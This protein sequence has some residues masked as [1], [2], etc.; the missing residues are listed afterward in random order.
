M[1]GARAS[2]LATTVALLAGAT[3]AGAQTVIPSAQVSV[4]GGYSTNPFLTTGDDLGV[5]SAQIGIVPQLEIID[6]TDQA[7]I[8]AFYDR[9]EYASKYDGNDGYGLNINAS[10][11]FDPRTS[12]S[13]FAS[14]S[15]SILGTANGFGTEPVIVTGT[16]TGTGSGTGTGTG[17]DTGTGTTPI[18]T[19]PIVT[20]SIIDTIGGDIGLVGFR[21]RRNALSAGLSGSY[22]P[23]EKSTWGFGANVA[24]NSYPDNGGLASSFRSYGVNTSYSRSLSERSS[25]GFQIGATLTD[26]NRLPSAKFVTPRLTYNTRLAERWTLDLAVGASFVDDGFSTG[27]AA[28]ATASLCRIAERAQFCLT[29]SRE[30]G[31]SGFGGARNQTSVTA[32][33]TYQLAE[34][35]S[36]SASGSYSQTSNGVTPLQGFQTRDQGYLSGSLTLNRRLARRLSA[37]GTLNYRDVNG[38]GV[39]IDADLG[40]RAGLSLAIGGRQ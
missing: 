20:T 12:L 19:T 30:P 10:T 28:S 23:D 7:T 16:G 1:I 40:A 33:Y 37:F 24:R 25:A 39:P 38:L 14:Y 3:G 35:T 13:F 22:R 5:A 17:T 34:A 32:V 36:L 27:V 11:Q 8:S 26:Y 18:V 29:A 6:G 4:S 21:Q 9:T 2:L 31:V 15:S